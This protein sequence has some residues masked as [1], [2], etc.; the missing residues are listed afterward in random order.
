MDPRCLVPFKGS[1]SLTDPRCRAHLLE[2]ADHDTVQR[3]R[4]LPF[5][6]QSPSWTDGDQ[7]LDPLRA[8]LQGLCPPRDGRMVT[9]KDSDPLI[10]IFKD[11]D[12]LRA[13]GHV[14]GL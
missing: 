2:V 9:F 12:P 11:S 8:P 14:Q 1:E 4:V 3:V 7:R 13:D 10:V 5:T 6:G